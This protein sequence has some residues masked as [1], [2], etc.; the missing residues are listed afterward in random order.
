MAPPTKSAAASKTCCAAPLLALLGLLALGGLI[1]AIV[2]GARGANNSNSV[3]HSEYSQGI[4][5]ED[6]A[7]ETEIEYPDNSITEKTVIIERNN[8]TINKNTT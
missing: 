2:L 3:D 8:E 7:A 5:I 6:G 1:A 4:P